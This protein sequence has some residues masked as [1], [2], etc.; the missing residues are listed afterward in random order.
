MIGRTNAVI[1]K[2]GSRWP[3]ADEVQVTYTGDMAEPR[4]ITDAAGN[5]YV[6]YELTSSGT[7]T[8]DKQV[9]ADICLVQGGGAGGMIGSYEYTYGGNGGP[10]GVMKTLPL[11]LYGSYDCTVGAGATPDTYGGDN[12][13][14]YQTIIKNEDLE[15]DTSPGI[16]GTGGGASGS[17]FAS[18]SNRGDGKTKYVFGDSSVFDYPLCDGGGGGACAFKNTNTYMW[19]FTQGGNGGVNGGDGGGKGETVVTEQG[20]QYNYVYVGDFPISYGGGRG[21]GNSSGRINDV[22]IDAEDGSTY[23]SGG[24]SAAYQM[25]LRASQ[26]RYIKTQYGAAG[27]GYQGVIFIRI[28]K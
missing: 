10:G 24:G 6:L 4:E 1:G 21:G 5:K 28:M 13:I 17:S 12:S 15:I 23:G 9:P 14:G 26:D 16:D 18:D 8:V 22:N 19:E 7:L 25:Y 2:S 11:V 3:S 27:K 20:G